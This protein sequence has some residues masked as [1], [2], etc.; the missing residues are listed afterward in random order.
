[1]NSKA[2]IALMKSNFT[3][4]LKMTM[5]EE[6]LHQIKGIWQMESLLEHKVIEELKVLLV[7]IERH[8]LKQKI[9]YLNWIQ[10]KNY[11]L[12]QLVINTIKRKVL[13]PKTEDRC[14]HKS[15]IKILQVQWH[16]YSQEALKVVP[17]FPIILN[18][19][20]FWKIW[21]NPV[22]LIFRTTRVSLSQF[23]ILKINFWF[24]NREGA[25]HINKC[26]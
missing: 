21:F 16:S 9:K 7:L 23:W 8:Q 11:H 14:L 25:S 1:M 10:I 18:R 26:R 19:M 12:G 2:A 6:T 3:V 22:Q 17:R 5:K 13:I 4:K 24:K 20:I 15:G